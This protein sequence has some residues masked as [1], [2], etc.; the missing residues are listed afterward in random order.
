LQPGQDL[1]VVGLGGVGMA[2][3]LTGRAITNSSGGR[4]IGIDSNAAK[5]EAAV[6]LGADAAYTP[7]E[8]ISL[9]ITAPVVVE[10]AGHARAFETA[11]AVTAPG[12]VTVTAGLPAPG[13]LSQI[14]PLAVTAEARTIV[15]SYLGSA[16][17]ARD[18]PIF[19]AL[20]RSGALP[21]EKLITAT[22]A[23]DDVNEA[24]DVLEAGDAVRQMI[25]F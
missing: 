23:L 1:I 10:A 14:P 21:A 18:S 12:G 20:W 6:D 9:G 8:A 11:F 13:A 5:H 19:E 17:P 16:V 15:G 22:I 25:V 3:I 24:M 2:A 4:V 7:E